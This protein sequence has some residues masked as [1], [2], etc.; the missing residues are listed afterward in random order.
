MT[1]GNDTKQDIMSAI[2]AG[3]VHMVPRW[4]FYLSSALT[5]CAALIIIAALL[6][7]ASF[8]IFTL[9]QTGVLFVPLFGVRGMFVFMRGLPLLLIA[10][11]LLLVLLLEALGRRYPLIY[12][13]P[14]LTSLLVVFILVLIG[15]VALERTRIHGALYLRARAHLLPPPIAAMYGA[16]GAP[17]PE[18]SRGT[19]AALTAQ[20]F[21]MTN[22]DG[23]TSTVVIDANTKRPLDTT[24]SVGQEVVVFGDEASGTIQALGVRTIDGEQ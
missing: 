17:V 16:S 22:D 8:T 10:L 19:I 11:V 5:A 9:R 15:G 20:G 13:R 2:R 18:V 21:V 3:K 1:D 4:R 12:R 14:L 7:F 6:Y 24:F 23:A